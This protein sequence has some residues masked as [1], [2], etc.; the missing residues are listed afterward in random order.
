M[1]KPYVVADG[2]PVLA[3]GKTAAMEEQL[4]SK[5]AKLIEYK[6]GN[7]MLSI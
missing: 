1:P 5:E 2:I 4:E 7:T 6:K 3:D